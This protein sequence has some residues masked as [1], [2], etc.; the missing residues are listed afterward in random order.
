MNRRDEIEANLTDV[1]DQI[2]S[3]CLAANRDFN[4]V[5]LIVVTKT[6]PS[7]DIEILA[8]LGVTDVG[9]NRD[10]DAKVKH[11]ELA[12]VPLTWHAI[13]QIQTNKAR[14]IASW[15]DVVH[16][17]DRPE[18]VIALDRVTQDR[19]KP[20]ETLIQ[21]D[22]DPSP[23]D[24][25]GG[26]SPD[27]MMELAKQISDAKGLKLAGVMAVAPLNL[28]PDSA[29]AQL[30]KYSLQLQLEYPEASIVSAGMSQDFKNAIKYGATHLRIGSLVL[31]HRP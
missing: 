19:E 10:Q 31:G 1:N 15:A 29:F 21:V 11:Q 28:D 8:E 6:W 25:R 17:V 30:Q 5:T 20:L 14:S 9:E 18:L 24:N 12:H 26:S 2:A 23:T 27:Q 7:S 13:G 3:A 16:S 4:S 22:L